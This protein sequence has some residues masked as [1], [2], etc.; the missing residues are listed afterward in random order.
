MYSVKR[1]ASRNRRRMDRHD[2]TDPLPPDKTPTALSPSPATPPCREEV[3]ISRR[4]G[5]V[6]QGRTEFYT[7]T[8]SYLTA[9]FNRTD[10][11]GADP[12]YTAP[13]P[14]TETNHLP[15]PSRSRTVT[16]ET[17]TALALLLAHLGPSWPI[18]VFLG[19]SLA[20]GL[21]KTASPRFLALGPKLR[22]P[23]EILC[24][25][26][27]PFLPSPR[28]QW[29]NGTSTP[30]PKTQDS[31]RAPWR[32]GHEQALFFALSSLLRW[33]RKLNVATKLLCDST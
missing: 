23:P 28:P 18:L 1:A 22:V 12:S 4:V 29:N 15:I 11:E 17:S 33:T 13:K 21:A 24:L 31:G 32:R 9:R 5:S 16:T 19:R 6:E 7:T 14:T 8:C 20:L 10:E 27:P 30:D 2:M 25:P 3:P 26:C